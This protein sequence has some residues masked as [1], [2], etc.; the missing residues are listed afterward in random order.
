ML[1]RY[2]AY[3]ADL[4]RARRSITQ[5]LTK[6]VDAGERDIKAVL[7]SSDIVKVK[8]CLE[9]FEANDASEKYFGLLLK[10][11]RAHKQTRTCPPSLVSLLRLT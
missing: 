8:A 4:D 6:A 7:V 9:T 3:P 1:E 5:R 11:L 10:R 2:S